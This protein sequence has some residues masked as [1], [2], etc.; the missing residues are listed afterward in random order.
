MV[1]G[2]CHCF[3]IFFSGNCV[4]KKNKKIG[5]VPSCLSQNLSFNWTLVDVIVYPTHGHG[6]K[7]VSR[8]MVV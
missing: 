2:L 8:Y 7:M 5:C 1:I 4:L 3:L 6:T